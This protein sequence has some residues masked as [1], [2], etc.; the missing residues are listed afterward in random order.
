MPATT[1]KL[2][3]ELVKKASALK[4]PGTSLSAFVRGLIESEYRDRRMREAV[5]NYQAFLQENS[6]EREAME[7]WES[8]PLSDSIE[9]SQT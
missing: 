8:A 9:P 7:V 4:P 2:D 5:R 3:S 6:A 1:V